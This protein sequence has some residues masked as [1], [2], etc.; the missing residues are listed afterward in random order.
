MKAFK[1]ICF[2]LVACI[3]LYVLGMQIKDV[4]AQSHFFGGASVRKVDV[5]QFDSTDRTGISVAPTGK[6]RLL[7]DDAGSN[8][9]IS[10]DGGAYSLLSGGAAA[11]VMND[12]DDVD[13]TGLTDAYVLKWNAG[14]GKWLPAV[15]IGDTST[16]GD[17]SGPLS[18]TDNAI[19]RF[20]GTGGK[21]LQDSNIV[22]DDSDNITG[23]EEITASQVMDVHII[24]GVTYAQTN[25]GIEAAIDA[26]DTGDVIFIPQGTY[27]FTGD[28]DITKSNITLQGA[29]RASTILQQGNSVNQ[30]VITLTGATGVTI[31][32]LEIDGNKA[33]QT[34]SSHGISAENSSNDLRIIN[35]YVHD[36]Y[37]DGIRLDSLVKAEI[38]GS[39]IEDIGDASI[40]ADS[41]GVGINILD[42]EQVYIHGNFID[43]TFSNGIHSFGETNNRTG[44]LRIQGNEIMGVITDQKSGIHLWEVDQG[45]VSGNFIH[46][47]DT[48]DS[49]VNAILVRGHDGSD[50]TNVTIADN[51]LI[52]ITGVGIECQDGN[53]VITGNMCVQIGTASD[54]NGIWVGNGADDVIITGNTLIGSPQRGIYNNGADNVIIKGNIIKNSGRSGIFHE[55]SNPIS[56]IIISGNQI[57]DDQGSPTMDYGVEFET[58]GTFSNIQVHGN[59]MSGQT[60]GEVSG[61]GPNTT[62]VTFHGTIRAEDQSDTQD[63]LE[64]SHDGSN[65]FVKTNTGAF[66]IRPVS[67]KTVFQ[68]DNSGFESVFNLVGDAA[69][70]QSVLAL[71]DAG[72]NQIVLTNDANSANDHDHNA[73]TDPTLYIHSDTDPDSDNTQWLALRH[74]KTNAKIT[75]GT[76]A[77]ITEAPSSAPSD[78]SFANGELA[79]WIDAAG[80]EVEVKG[81]DSAGDVITATIGSGAG[82][83]ASDDLSDSDEM[84]SAV[85]L[86]VAASD[87]IHRDSAD[88]LCDGTAD[89]VQIQAAIDWISANAPGGS[90]VGGANGKGTLMLLGGTYNIASTVNVV[91]GLKIQ[92]ES[93]EST[94]IKMAASANTNLFDFDQS[95]TTTVGAGVWFEDIW[96]DGNSGGNTSGGAW[97]SH[98]GPTNRPMWDVHFTRCAFFSFAGPVIDQGSPWGFRMLQC[99]IEDCE[100][101]GVYLYDLGAASGNDKTSGAIMTNNK[102]IQNAGPAIHINGVNFNLIQANELNSDT[103]ESTVY[104]EGAGGNVIVGNKFD[105]E[106]ANQ[107]TA[108][109]VDATSNKNLIKDNTINGID[110]GIQI[111]SGATSNIVAGNL[112]TS[113]DATEISDAGT[114]SVFRGNLGD[115]SLTLIDT[116]LSIGDNA[117]IIK[118]LTSPLAGI[119]LDAAGLEWEFRNTSGTALT[120]MGINSGILTSSAL[121]IP[122]TTTLNTIA[123]TWPGADGSNGQQL[124]TNGSGTLSWA[125]AGSGTGAFSDAG[126]PIVQNT[127]TKDVVIGTTHNSAAKLGVD[128]DADQVQ[129]HIQENA[130]QTNY[131]MIIEESDTTNTFRVDTNGKIDTAAGIDGIGAVDFDIGSADVLDV[132]VQT[133]GGTIVLDGDV[134]IPASS[135]YK[136]SSD[137]I[138]SDSGGTMTLSN[139]DAIDATTETTL[140]AT[141]ELDSLQGNLGVAHLNSGTSASSS[142]YWRGDATWATP[143]GGGSTSQK[144][145]TWAAASTQYTQSQGANADGVAPLGT[146]TG[147]NAEVTYVAFDDTA[148]EYRGV[149]F[150]VPSDVDTSDTATF[151]VTWYS[152]TQ[153]TGSAQWVFE[154]KAVN[155]AE[156]WDQ[157]PTTRAATSDA[158][159]GT[160]D[161][162][163]ETTWE[164]SLSTLGW[165]A[166][167]T[168]VGYFYRDGDGTNGTDDL[169]DDAHAV[170]F[171]V[172]VPRQ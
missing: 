34:G 66:V 146:D 48:A 49:G 171:H 86:T 161:Q 145:Y 91:P 109:Y 7:Y 131:V 1:N 35:V 28:I 157:A 22:I 72:G 70:D 103:L 121:V 136:V 115:D 42:S 5:L 167:E 116:F 101:T 69:L 156:S 155:E 64:L 58:G 14:S 45:V 52:N 79:F 81:K 53:T 29:G 33:N 126:D 46:D 31:R 125:A 65:A 140:E 60:S 44:K 30:N 170:T 96:F 68:D 63:Y 99:H 139:I 90:L 50:T 57:F 105:G 152:A 73:A 154:E 54:A 43:D 21:T 20:D 55:A 119:Y 160:V 144:L 163:T 102:F 4:F 147:T 18:S 143:A 84:H 159:Q 6:S 133:D 123:Y 128:G 82:A 114:S 149:Q 38:E 108:V 80:D 141:L 98:S 25:V 124:T 17:V 8:L 112:F 148:D 26:A 16:A 129:L 120:T 100:D 24:D 165:T 132:S 92:G 71:E 3:L 51:D 172:R 106:G 15:D 59:I 87:S 11:T 135:A 138:L 166:G 76:G 10:I 62:P 164:V 74:D 13:T 134:T 27:T 36:T 61:N 88:Y 78:G 150:V 32:D 12:L 2:F 127:T 137:N 75:V 110:D 113:V 151:A 85:T 9:Y 56:D 97:A 77:I 89:D 153:T 130:T 162:L 168:V 39:R 117:Y 122:G 41:F 40:D 142:T 104:L 47:M 37:L 95:D 93:F 158:V 83:S 169:S 67:G 23:V 19:V 111:I 107:G 118:A 94:Q